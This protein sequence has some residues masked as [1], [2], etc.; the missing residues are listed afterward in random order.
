MGEVS[1]WAK[2]FTTLIAIAVAYWVFI[3]DKEVSLKRQE[4]DKEE[5]ILI[6]DTVHLTTTR[7][8]FEKHRDF[9][10][11]RV[12]AYKLHSVIIT[13]SKEVPQSVLLPYAQYK[14]IQEFY[15]R[16][17]VKKEKQ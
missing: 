7:N 13:D 12:A 3:F 4:R 11:D 10:F 2:I 5:E 15:D 14:I 16:A 8:T 17:A 9:I 6:D 1:T